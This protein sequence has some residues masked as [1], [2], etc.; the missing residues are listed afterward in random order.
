MEKQ[1]QQQIEKENEVR[2]IWN[3]IMNSEEDMEVEIPI[4]K[5]EFISFV[6]RIGN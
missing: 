6:E 3:T 1:L 2:S 4:S 5:E